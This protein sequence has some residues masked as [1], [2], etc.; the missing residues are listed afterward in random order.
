ML[1]RVSLGVK[2][3]PMSVK[4]SIA[5]MLLLMLFVHSRTW[6]RIKTRNASK[7][8]RPRIMIRELD[9]FCRNSSIVAPDQIDL[10][11]ILCGS[12]PKVAFPPK[13]LHVWRRRSWT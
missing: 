3:V 6:G 7:S 9:V 11:P 5:I 2:V 8:H 13:V 12:N 1:R 10:F 4:E